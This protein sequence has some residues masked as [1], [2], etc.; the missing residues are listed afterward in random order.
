MDSM[1]LVKNYYVACSPNE[2]PPP[3]A[4]FALSSVEAPPNLFIK[5]TSETARRAGS[6]L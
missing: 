5:P 3:Y 2:L 1:V 6:H 4:G